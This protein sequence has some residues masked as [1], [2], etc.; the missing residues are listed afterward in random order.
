MKRRF[1]IRDLLWLTAQVA[2]LVAWRLDHQRMQAEVEALQLDT[3]RPLNDIRSFEIY[4]SLR[5]Q[6]EPESSRFKV[7]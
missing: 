6:S 3:P 7:F 2:V 1:S 5:R 4:P